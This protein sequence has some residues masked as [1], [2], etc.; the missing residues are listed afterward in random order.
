[1]RPRTHSGDGAPERSI[2]LRDE[3]PPTLIE[4]GDFFL[5]GAELTAPGT[6]KAFHHCLRLPSK[7]CE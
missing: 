4:L 5:D 1:V 3:R 2:D 6:L 7:L